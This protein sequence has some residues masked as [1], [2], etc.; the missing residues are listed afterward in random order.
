M[1][2]GCIWRAEPKGFALSVVRSGSKRLVK[3]DYI[4]SSPNIQK[5]VINGAG[6]IG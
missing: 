2:S 5:D 6:E 1:H 4:V 3:G